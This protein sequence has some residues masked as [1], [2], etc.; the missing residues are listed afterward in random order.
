MGSDTEGNKYDYNNYYD[1]TQ[2]K[3]A[4]TNESNKPYYK[5]KITNAGY[6]FE[7]HKI[8]TEDGYI[9]TAWRIPG[10]LSES[11]EDKSKRKPIILQHGIF[12]SSYT[13]FFLNINDTLPILLSEKGYDVW[14]TNNRGN[15]FSLEHV[16]KEEFDSNLYYSKFWDFS[17]HEMAVYDFPANVNYIKNITKYS[18]INY[19]GHSQGTLQY[20]VY[21]TINSTFID[22]NIERF[23]S[24]GTVVNIFNT[25]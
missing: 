8:Q 9:L 3:E 21:Y 15:I 23:I 12:D 11:S 24:I 25:V 5:E 16:N 18:K 2:N 19:L 6:S 13:W 1:Y 10:K 20:F 17:L 7:E 4:T 22:K 14:L